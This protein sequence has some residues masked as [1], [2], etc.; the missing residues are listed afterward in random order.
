M[1]KSHPHRVLYLIEW[2]G[3]GGAENN[4]AQLVT[5][6]H[7]DRYEPVVRPAVDGW[8]REH[9]VSHAVDVRV[10]ET[11][12]MAFGLPFLGRGVSLPIIADLARLIRRERIALVHAY[13]WAM[14]LHGVIAARLAG[15]PAVYAVRGSSQEL[16]HPIR[17]R[18]LRVLAL[19]GCHFTGVS[20]D[21]AVSLQHDCGV[22][23]D[24]ITHV[25]NGVDASLYVPAGSSAEIRASLGLD[26][27][28]F[29]IGTVANLRPIKG[30]EYLL[31]AIP[32]VESRSG[33]L[34][35]VFAGGGVL[36]E[37]LQ[38]MVAELRVSSP[39]VFLGERGDVSRVLGAFDAFVLPSLSEGMSNALLQAMSSGLPC[40][41]TAVG[42][43]V[44]VLRHRETGLLVPPGDPHR[45]AESITSLAASAEFRR[46]LATAARREVEQHYTLARMVVRN[47]NVY[48][49]CLSEERGARQGR[50]A[51]DCHAGTEVGGGRQTPATTPIARSIGSREA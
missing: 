29:T 30:H 39:V 8:L 5:H 12:R 38:H 26:P 41:A 36:R 44:E 20:R 42:G 25:P 19:L 33:P 46:L 15:V 9:L 24:Q 10:L 34:Q 18:M 7:R 17:R 31:R 27:S 2:S 1:R 37:G 51:T 49:Q 11:R 16:A 40:V 14:G 23:A 45:L 21:I 35:V 3:R 43:N 48:A 6:L 28:R 13:M 4:L 32:D 50:D 22:P 47:E